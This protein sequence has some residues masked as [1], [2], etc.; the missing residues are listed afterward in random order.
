MK[1][2]TEK[3]IM[4]LAWHKMSFWDILILGKEIKKQPN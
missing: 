3:D 2:L 4:N 1:K